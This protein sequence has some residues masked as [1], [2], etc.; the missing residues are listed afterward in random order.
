MA[1]V[2]IGIGSNLGDRQ[3]NI[4]RALAG[5][6]DHKSVTVEKI[7]S[8]IETDPLGGPPQ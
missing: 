1:T 4:D 7:S 5:L 8:F 2:F 6:R 3:D